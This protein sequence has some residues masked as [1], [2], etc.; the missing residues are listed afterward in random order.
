MT[1][2]VNMAEGK[3]ASAFNAT[4]ETFTLVV[5][6]GQKIHLLIGASADPTT[7]VYS[8]TQTNAY[9][10]QFSNYV[11][12]ASIGA[13]YYSAV[14]SASGTITIKAAKGGVSV[15]VGLA[16]M[17]ANNVGSVIPD[18]IPV[19]LVDNG[20][21]SVQAMNPTTAAACLLVQMIA[22]QPTITTGSPVPAGRTKRA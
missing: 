22:S 4:D 19:F 13:A 10:K 11:G 1:A 18:G 17:A 14:A 9:S 7:L 8:D 3:G 2:P 12:A 21:T 15:A 20:T 5:V 6:A 16:A